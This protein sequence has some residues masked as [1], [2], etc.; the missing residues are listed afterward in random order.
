MDLKEAL[1]ESESLGGEL[2][3]L[4]PLVVASESD[5]FLRQAK[6]K[7]PSEEERENARREVARLGG[8]QRVWDRIQ[9]IVAERERIRRELRIHVRKVGL[10]GVLSLLDTDSYERFL[11][12]AGQIRIRR[13][14]PERREIGSL[15][16]GSEADVKAVLR[17]MGGGKYEVT[18]PGGE[19][20]EEKRELQE[21]GGPPKAEELMEV[22]AQWGLGAPRRD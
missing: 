1:E 18:H 21:F 20:S 11:Q 2:G 6:V 5:T 22:L 12:V 19:D 7:V 16:A 3:R 8:R 14:A 4:F 17:E 9:E 10:R 15:P 13:L